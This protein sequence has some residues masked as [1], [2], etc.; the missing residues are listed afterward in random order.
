MEDEIGLLKQK[1]KQL[2]RQQS[3]LELRLLIAIEHGD[4]VEAQLLDANNMLKQEIRRRE[5]LEI[6]LKKVAWDREREKQD[7]QIILETLIA[8]GDAIDKQWQEEI[9]LAQ[10]IA[11]TDALT[12]IANRRRFDT[13]LIQIWQELQSQSLPLSLLLCDVD[14]FKLYNDNYGHPMGDICLKRVAHALSSAMRGKADLV[15]RYGG[16]EFGIIL[17]NTNQAN[18]IL[19]AS[20]IQS[21]LAQMAIPHS[22]S[23]VSQFVTL[24]IGIATVVPHSSN[25]PVELIA[26]ADR[27]LYQAKQQ[28]RNCLCG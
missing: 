19:I 4:A 28:G 9:A 23:S 1:I 7:L 16:E 11:E 18:A 15:C 22:Q 13:Y 21:L 3:D 26:T 27:M 5:Q 17:P 14:F 8:H 6:Y 10:L 20:R 2:E 12:L 24:S 25:S